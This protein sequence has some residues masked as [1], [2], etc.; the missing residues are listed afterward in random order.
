M[1]KTADSLI[2]PVDATEGP[3][4]P[5]QLPSVGITEARKRRRQIAVEVSDLRAQDPSANRTDTAA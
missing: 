1:G 4:S 5:T 2:A 3:S